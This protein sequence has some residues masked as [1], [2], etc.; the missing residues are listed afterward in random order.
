MYIHGNFNG[1]PD[2]ETVVFNDNKPLLTGSQSYNGVV[3][4]HGY[5][6]M[7]NSR[8]DHTNVAVQLWGYDDIGPKLGSNDKYSPGDPSKLYTK[9][10]L[11]NIQI[12]V[13]FAQSV[14]GWGQ[15]GID[16]SSSYIGQ[17]SGAAFHIS[18]SPVVKDNEYAGYLRLSED[19]VINNFVTGGDAW[20]VA[21]GKA[22]LAVE[23]KM[24]LNMMLSGHGCT[25]TR[26]EEPDSVF[27]FMVMVDSAGSRFGDLD[28]T[29]DNEESS[30]G[31]NS[32]VPY[33]RVYSG[34]SETTIPV[35]TPS[36]LCDGMEFYYSDPAMGMS[37][38]LEVFELPQAE[39]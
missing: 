20:F 18:D 27:N 14:Y 25:V 33:Y 30:N 23:L 38:M 16:V 17:S 37:L 32:H 24:G 6:T 2:A 11:S 5:L 35:M 4:R 1:D 10:T 34:S 19:T 22:P 8:V 9:A 29:T 3:V 39:E 7:D 13:T 36:L 21:F 26:G 15:V 28:V 31:A 12:D